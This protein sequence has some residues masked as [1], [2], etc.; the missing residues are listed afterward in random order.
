MIIPGAATG[1]TPVIWRGRRT[2][3]SP[4]FCSRISPVP[5]IV[6]AFGDELVAVSG[7]ATGSYETNNTATLQTARMRETRIQPP[8]VGLKV[9]SYWNKGNSIRHESNIAD[10]GA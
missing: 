4:S 2:L 7:A 5:L 1:A 9:K 6:A 3:R 10:N 8:S